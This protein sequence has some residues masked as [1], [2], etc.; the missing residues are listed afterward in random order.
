MNSINKV[1][2]IEL[3]E[4]TIIGSEIDSKQ[5]LLTVKNPILW[6]GGKTYLLLGKP[7]EIAI[8]SYIIVFGYTTEDAHIVNLYNMTWKRNEKDDESRKEGVTPDD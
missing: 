2:I 5:G 4:M 1:Y 3:N 7:K 6:M 8:N